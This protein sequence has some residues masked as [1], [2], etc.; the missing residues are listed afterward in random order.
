MPM[1]RK[2]TANM[3]ARKRLKFVR[4]KRRST[5]RRKFTR[6]RRGF[7][8]AVKN[9]ILKTA[10]TKYLSRRLTD[11][12]M[13]EQSVPSRFNMRHNTLEYFHIFN[14]T[15]PDAVKHPIPTQGDGDGNRNGDEIY[16]TGIRIAGSIQVPAIYKNAQFKM[17]L[18]EYNDSV[19]GSGENIGTYNAVMHNVANSVALDTFQHDRLRPKYLGTLRVPTKDINDSNDGGINF[20]RWIP[21]KRKMTF[22][23]DDSPAVAMGIKDKLS[24]LFMPYDVITQTSGNTIGVCNVHATLYYK[25][26]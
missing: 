2:A 12:N 1:K 3:S 24:L 20:K 5:Y 7:A 23:Q 9:V 4:A 26:P 16:A 10:E 17:F 13:T 15:N 11:T 25:D 14:N 8:K 22:R 18:V 21:L 6:G 19:F